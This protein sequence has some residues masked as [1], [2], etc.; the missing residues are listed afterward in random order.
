MMTQ[1]E[2]LELFQAQ[3]KRR[4]PLLVFSASDLVTYQNLLGRLQA[5]NDVVE[6][7][8]SEFCDASGDI[9]INLLIERVKDTLARD[10][11]CVLH[12]LGELLRR[13]PDKEFYKRLFYELEAPFERGW[14][15]CAGGLTYELPQHFEQWYRRFSRRNDLPIYQVTPSREKHLRKVTVVFHELALPFPQ[16]LCY[17]FCEY[18]MVWENA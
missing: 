5:S 17:P 16:E 3:Q 14:D 6:I 7:R 9:N 12:P 8:V 2:V 1:N 13:V 18:L 15:A 4:F 10:E 11:N